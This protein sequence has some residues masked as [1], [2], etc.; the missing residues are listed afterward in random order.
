MIFPDE[1]TLQDALL[2]EEGVC[3]ECGAVSEP[4]ECLTAASICE[5]CGHQ[6]CLPAVMLVKVRDALRAGD[7][8]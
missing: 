6:W 3:I 1:A 7:E 8:F 4:L 5:E 2:W